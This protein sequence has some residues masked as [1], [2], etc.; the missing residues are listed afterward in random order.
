MKLRAE[1]TQVHQSNQTPVSRENPTLG[2]LCTPETF[3]TR[4]LHSSDWEYVVNDNIPNRLISSEEESHCQ[5][6]TATKR[7]KFHRD[8][9]PVDP[10]SK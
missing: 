4:K 7:S 2:D 6:Y 9:G 5:G 10:S 1:V 8:T 3:L